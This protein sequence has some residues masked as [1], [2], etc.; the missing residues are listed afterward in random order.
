MTAV[1]TAD[2]FPPGEF[3]AGTSTPFYLGDKTDAKCTEQSFEAELRD[4][5][6][7][8]IEQRITATLIPETGGMVAY[9]VQGVA[10]FAAF[11]R[12]QTYVTIASEEDDG[13]RITHE[14]EGHLSV[15][16]NGVIA[17]PNDVEGASPVIDTIVFAWPHDEFDQSAWTTA[18]SLST[19]ADAKAGG[20]T[21]WGTASP[22]GPWPWSS[23]WD[24]F[25]ALGADIIG[26]DDGSV[27][28]VSNP[29]AP[30][31]HHYFRQVISV[32][33]T[34]AHRM[35]VG[36]DNYA[37][38]YV[39]GILIGTCGDWRHITWLDVD[40]TPGFHVVAVHLV[41]YPATIANPCGYSWA[42]YSEDGTF[43]EKSRAANTV[44]VEYQADP[45]GMS[46]GT[47]IRLA[48]KPYVT[49]GEAWATAITLAF[50]DVYDSNGDPWETLTNI[51]AEVGSS[52]LD[53]IVK[54]MQS[55]AVIVMDP[56]GWTLYAYR[57][58]ATPPSSG[59]EF[60]V[61]RNI[62]SL[63]HKTEDAPATGIWVRSDGLGWTKY[64]TG[65]RWRKI[66]LGSEVAAFDVAIQS[67]EILAKL[68]V[69]RREISLTFAPDAAASPSE[70]PWLNTNF[71][72][73]CLAIA[74]DLPPDLS[75]VSERVLAL[76]CAVSQGAEEMQVTVTLA[77]RIEELNDR[78]ITELVG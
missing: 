54:L 37:E 58:D 23:E 72:Q 62:T 36:A 40:L 60:E 56:G 50:D 11:F 75:P 59:V 21:E 73:G 14:L 10:A 31:Q 20:A 68:G 45:P 32:A 7:S 24:E 22:Y 67:A 78:M 65:P 64:G 19:V 63:T 47:T 42:L 30:N 16:G 44:H 52:I 41:N 70:F 5:G 77:D 9:K 35:A 4:I 53:L 29:N 27:T 69:N 1:L 51:T 43:V 18:N 12:R 6:S 49:N 25:N 26:P 38:V 2:Y 76:G 66:D 55:Y 74:P 34:G 3:P 46:V 8:K 61:G 48:L 33:T 28:N 57:F 13:Q 15:F 71:V 17:T 39:D